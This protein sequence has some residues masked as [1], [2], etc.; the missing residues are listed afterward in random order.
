LIDAGVGKE[1]ESARVFAQE[2]ECVGRNMDYLVMM[3]LR[4]CVTSIDIERGESLNEFISGL[5]D[6]DHPFP[7]PLFPPPSLTDLLEAKHRP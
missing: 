7:P 1:E 2:S 6:D 3:C 5:F 4:E